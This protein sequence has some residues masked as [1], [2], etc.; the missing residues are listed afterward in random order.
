MIAAISAKAIKEVEYHV[1]HSTQWV[2][3]LGGGTEESE[4]RMQHALNVM[5]PYVGEL[6][7]DEPLHE[8]LAVSGVTVL[9]SS[10]K[11][12]WLARVTA[13]I[14]EAGLTVPAAKEAMANG[15]R[16]DHTEHLG[17]LLAEMQVLARKHPGATW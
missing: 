2:M 10:L 6:F 12:E 7:Q 8:R 4:Q 13:V 17:Y 14:E 9:P 5:W 3:R 16:G 15:R 1:D 11:E